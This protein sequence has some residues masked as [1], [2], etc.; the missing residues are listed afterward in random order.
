MN[1]V[2]ANLILIFALARQV[3]AV[4]VMGMKAVDVCRAHIHA[5]ITSGHPLCQHLTEFRSKR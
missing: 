3:F 2:K 5:G 4:E 1:D